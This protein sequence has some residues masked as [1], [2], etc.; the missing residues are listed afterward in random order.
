MPD[1]YVQFKGGD[2][3][4]IEGGMGPF[5]WLTCGLSQL[6]KWA[7]AEGK[8][9][10][11]LSELIVRGTCHDTERLAADVTAALKEAPKELTGMLADLAEIVGDGDGDE[12]ASLTDGSEE[13]EESESWPVTRP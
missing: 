1:L 10:P 4:G 13:D 7:G 9:Y 2:S 5:Y 11:V 12:S 8:R 3:L 6:A